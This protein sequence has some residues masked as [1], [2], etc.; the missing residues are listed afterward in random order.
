[1]KGLDEN[2]GLSD[3]VES[4][5]G[6]H[7]IMRQPLTPDTVIGVNNTGNEVTFRFAA[8]EQ[9]FSAMIEAWT[10]SADVVWNDGFENPDMQAIFG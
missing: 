5:Y 6:F 9:Q 10:E 2:Y 4:A 3:V 8:A 7:I 1:V